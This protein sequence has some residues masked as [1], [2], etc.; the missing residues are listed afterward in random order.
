MPEKTFSIGELCAEFG[1]TPRALRFY[2]Y[3]E[4]LAPIR[5]GQ[6]RIFTVRDRARLK[7]IL[8]GK[9]FGFSLAEI[10]DLLDLY[11]LGDGQVTQLAA[12]LEIAEKHR[13]ELIAKRDELNSAI[14]DLAKQMA[15]AEDLLAQKSKSNAAA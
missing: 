10:K 1:V 6:R 14:E 15:V 13:A 5:D 2:E 11:H 7:L 4:L 12:T 3:K 8:R 9:R